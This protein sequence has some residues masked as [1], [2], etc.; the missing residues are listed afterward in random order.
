MIFV[1][2]RG[3]HLAVGTWN[4]RTV[5]ITN[6]RERERER[7]RERD[8]DRER[9]GERETETEIERV[10]ESER[11]RGRI[12]LRSIVNMMIHVQ[13]QMTMKDYVD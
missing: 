2:R 4:I 13:I 10:R 7:E 11:E 8:R 6:Q 3:A 5:Y 9:E 12:L 1:N